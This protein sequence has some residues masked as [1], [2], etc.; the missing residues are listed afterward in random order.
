MIMIFVG[1]E[2]MKLGIFN[3]IDGDLFVSLVIEIL[4]IC[5]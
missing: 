2:I 5:F 1:E 4:E 3:F